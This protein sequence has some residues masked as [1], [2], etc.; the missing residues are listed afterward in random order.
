MPI[1][2]KTHVNFWGGE[3]KGGFFPPPG[4]LREVF[5]FVV[6]P[7]KFFWEFSSKF[8]VQKKIFEFSTFV[9]FSKFWVKN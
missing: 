1:G 2:L 9:V 5:F 3:K 7:P 6:G 4:F 8:V